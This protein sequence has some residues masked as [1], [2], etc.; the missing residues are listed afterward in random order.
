[1]GKMRKSNSDIPEEETETAPRGREVE[2]SE[3]NNGIGDVEAPRQDNT[4]NA[5]QIVDDNV[6]EDGFDDVPIT[7]KDGAH[8]M[9]AGPFSL[10]SAKSFKRVFTAKID[11]DTEADKEKLDEWMKARE[12]NPSPK[13][14]SYFI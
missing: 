1:M 10:F 7:T 2:A 4:E 6:K 14:R 3:T 12:Y 9:D 11:L 8:N 13:F 5:Q